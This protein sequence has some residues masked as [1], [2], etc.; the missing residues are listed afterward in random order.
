MLEEARAVAGETERRGW[1]AVTLGTLAEVALLRDRRER[2]H[3]LFT[4]AREQYQ[5]GG[6][7]EGAAAMQARL[8]SLDEDLQSPRKASP[9]RTVAT[10]KPKRRQ[11]R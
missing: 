1:V 3:V 5:A 10:P 4:Q 11:S 6:S 2:A 9:R 7:E 8:Q